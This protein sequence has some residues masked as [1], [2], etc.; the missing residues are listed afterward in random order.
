[1]RIFRTAVLMVIAISLITLNACNKDEKSSPIFNEKITKT[2]LS[3]I[4]KK[5]S[6]DENLE[7]DDINNFLKGLQRMHKDSLV[8]MKV[9]EIIENELKINRDAQIKQAMILA[10]RAQLNLN[11]GFYYKGIK[12][13]KQNDTNYFLVLFDIE[14]KSDKNIV[15]I[16]GQLQYKNAAG[17]LV[18]IHKVELK[19]KIDVGRVSSFQ[20]LY[21]LNEA[22]QRDQILSTLKGLSASWLPT[23]IKFEDG[24]EIKI[25]A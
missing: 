22:N 18:K 24:S 19:D 16:K 6:E 13:A 15:E 7:L 25:D 11:H 17:Q 20:N 3:S 9:S 14:N 21:P 8:G 23:Y 12:P 1:M 5:M 4:V 2:N 10:N